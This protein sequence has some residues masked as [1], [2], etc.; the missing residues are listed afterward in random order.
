MITIRIVIDASVAI[1]AEFYSERIEKILIFL[2][3]QNKITLYAPNH[4]K[5]E[6]KKYIIYQ[7]KREYIFRYYEELMERIIK[8]YQIKIT[9][10]HKIIPFINTA[11]GMTTDP[12]DI[13]YIA[14]ALY[15]NA[16]IWTRDLAH[17][18]NYP[19]VVYTENLIALLKKYYHFKDVFHVSPFPTH[20]YSER[21]WVCERQSDGNF[22][23]YPKQLSRRRS[24]Y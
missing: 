4:L 10:T 1:S 20:P 3:D 9:P 14:C 7:K 24:R 11:G 13:D 2:R 19:K 17:F 15:K 23:C 8:K 16:Y 5:K 18:E 21:V 12:N 6:I 22:E